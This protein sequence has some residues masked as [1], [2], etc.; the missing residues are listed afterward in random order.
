MSDQPL[1]F[2]NIL[3]QEIVDELN[4]MKM[5]DENYKIHLTHCQEEDCFSCDKYIE[6]HQEHQSRLGHLY[7][8]KRQKESWG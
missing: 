8:S 3:G 2:K 7:I 4:L 6:I 1:Q 5:M